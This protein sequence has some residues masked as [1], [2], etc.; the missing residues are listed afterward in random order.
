MYNFSP[1]LWIYS[2]SYYEGFSGVVIFTALFN[3]FSF[4][5]V[6]PHCHLFPVKLNAFLFLETNARH[7]HAYDV[8]CFFVLRQSSFILPRTSAKYLGSTSLHP[9]CSPFESKT[10]TLLFYLLLSFSQAAEWPSE[11]VLPTAQPQS[12]LLLL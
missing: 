3:F 7:K 10:Q 9:S 11:Q 4:L 1:K 6:Y 12:D 8:W 2:Y 5:C